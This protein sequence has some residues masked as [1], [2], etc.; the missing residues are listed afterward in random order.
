MDILV[1]ICGRPSESG[2]GEVAKVDKAALAARFREVHT[3]PDCTE[4]AWL[5][6][7]ILTAL[8]APN[9]ALQLH[10]LRSKV[11][12]EVQLQLEQ[13][14]LTGDIA[15]KPQ[16]RNQ[17]K[18]AAAWKTIDVTPEI[19]RDPRMTGIT[20]SPSVARALKRAIKEQIWLLKRYE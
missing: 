6:A 2:G 19:S 18:F 3:D 16:R 8:D 10:D 4:E 5:L 15:F 14:H 1:P 17:R 9:L 20:I 11:M 7:Q 12:W 13:Q